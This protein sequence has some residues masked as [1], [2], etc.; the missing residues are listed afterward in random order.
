MIGA[1]TKQTS[2]TTRNEPKTVKEP[3][4][5]TGTTYDLCKKVKQADGSEKLQRIGNVF[6]RASGS[7]GVAYLTDDDGTKYELPIFAKSK[8][9]EGPKQAAAA[10]PEAA[11]AA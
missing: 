4:K 8:R 1:N 5:V 9:R 3:G 7:G 2:P 11:V 6:I 10:Q